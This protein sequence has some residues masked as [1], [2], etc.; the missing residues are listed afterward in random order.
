MDENGERKRATISD[1]VHTLDQAQVSRED[2]LRFKLKIDEEQLDD[3][4]SYN[5]LKEHLEDNSDT[6]QHEDGLYK[7][8]SIKDHRGPYTSTDPEYL[9][10]SY[11]LLIEWATGEMTWEPLRNIIADDPYSCA[12]YAKNFDLLNT[13][14][15][16]QLK[17]HART[18]K[19]IIRTLKKSKNRQAKASMRYSMDGKLQGI[20]CIPYKLDVQNG[21]NKWRDVIDLEIEQIKEYQVFRDHGKVIYEK[22]KVISACKEY[23]KIEYTLCLMSNIVGNSRQDLWKMDIS[24]KN[25]MKLSIQELFLRGTSDL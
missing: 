24:P 5:Q 20:M 12:V 7:F 13:Q 21:H 17:R 8:K 25:P 19:R 22:S 3:L 16:K 10:I 2:M 23:Q 15:L 14:G 9:G 1:L 6:G 11:N 18:A 4:I